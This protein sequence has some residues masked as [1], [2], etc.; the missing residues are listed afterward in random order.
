[1]NNSVSFVCPK[2][3]NLKRDRTIGLVI[4]FVFLFINTFVC[5][6]FAGQSSDIE[7]VDGGI[8]RG[9]I[10]SH[11]DGVYVVRSATLGTLRVNESD[12]RLIRPNVGSSANKKT[13]KVPGG[14]VSPEIQALQKSMMNDKAIMDL[15][16]SL[17][18]APEMQELLKSPDIIK[19]IQSGDIS[20]L[21]SNPKFIRLMENPKVKEIQKKVLTP[22]AG[23]K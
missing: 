17:Q 12:I 4:F 5:S 14:S 16:Q 8:I 10:I 7:L 3:G 21:M 13:I 23:R 11:R 20:A 2:R 15:I 18:Q 9:E 6:V 1:M 19:V 22:D